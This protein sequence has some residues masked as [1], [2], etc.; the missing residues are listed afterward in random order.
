MGEASRFPSE[1]GSAATESLGAS[2]RTTRL[3][4]VL[5]E[6]LTAFEKVTPPSQEAILAAHPDLADALRVHFRNLEELHGLAGGFNPERFAA[7]RAKEECESGRIGDFELIREIGRGGMGVV[8]EAHQISLD[9]R[10][11]VK[12]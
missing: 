12:L 3:S 5:D 10:V 9:R 11:A 1:F 4:D 7:D 8:Y 6:Y 2:E